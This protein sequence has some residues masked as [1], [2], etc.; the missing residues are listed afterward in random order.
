MSGMNRI[1]L[2]GRVGSEPELRQ[3]KDG[4][5][6]LWISVATDR[7][8]KKDGAWEDET[9]WHRVNLFGTAAER[10][11]R[12]AQKGTLVAVEGSM[13]YEKWTDED[14]KVRRM[15]K[16]MADR[17]SFLDRMRARPEAHAPMAAE[18]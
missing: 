4:V 15:P 17:I 12:L 14:G 8:V 10:T 18:A 9:D 2:V 3:S 11:M 7:R 5:P 1:V 13:I 16:V 6:W